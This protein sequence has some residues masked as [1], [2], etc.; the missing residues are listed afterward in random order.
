MSIESLHRIDGQRFELLFIDEVRTIGGLVG[1]ETMPFFDNVHLLRKLSIR[2]DDTEEADR[3]L[4][5]LL[6]SFFSPLPGCL[7]LPADECTEPLWLA[8]LNW[9]ELSRW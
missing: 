5:R 2:T 7:E 4:S 6:I 8:S 1:G 3:A 9:F